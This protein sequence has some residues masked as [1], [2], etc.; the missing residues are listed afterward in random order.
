MKNAIAFV[1]WLLGYAMRPLRPL[2]FHSNFFTNN[3]KLMSILASKIFTAN[4]VVTFSDTQPDNHW[5]KNLMLSFL[6]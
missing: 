3:T 5:F 2:N 4:N 6:T 1:L